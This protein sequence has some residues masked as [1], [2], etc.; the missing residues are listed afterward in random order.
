MLDNEMELWREY[1]STKN[2]QIRDKLVMAYLKV[3]K[4]LAGRLSI[5][6]PACMSQDDLES[7]GV[8]GLLEAIDRFDP[9]MGRD[10]ESYAYSRVRGAMLD[11]IRRVNWV[12]RT[13]WHKLQELKEARFR[14]E[15][16]GNCTITEENLARE[17]GVSVTEVRR[18]NTHFHRVF[19]LSLDEMVT[20]SAGETVR[21]GDMVHDESSLDP[22]DVVV[23]EDN[24]RLLE[25][26]LSCL[27]D[28]D[29]L[30]FALYYQEG[31]TLKEIGKVMGISE[32][33]VCQVHSRALDRLRAK[34]KSQV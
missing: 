30:V 3:V 11:E 6:L 9:E 19:S 15:S 2:Q 27:D 8:L 18:L 26:A 10:F 24:Y 28:K 5:R 31:L 14:L 17:M 23:E 25:E 33:R 20:A 12:P 13:V 4:Y 21:F 7:C 34:I 32:S 1:K 16:A 29:Q 22:L